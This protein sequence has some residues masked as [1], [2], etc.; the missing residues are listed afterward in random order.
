MASGYHMGQHRDRTFSSLQKVLLDTVPRAS[1]YFRVL[2]LSLNAF[3][4]PLSSSLPAASFMAT[5]KQE[6]Y[7]SLNLTDEFK[8]DCS[9][10]A[11]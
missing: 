8:S 6:D 7:L 11:E 3:A 1:R 5:E 2:I 10:G 4:I 9:L